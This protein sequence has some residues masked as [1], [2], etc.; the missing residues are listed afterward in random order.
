M[1]IEGGFQLTPF[2]KKVKLL[3][4]FIALDYKVIKKK[5]NISE[6]L[7]IAKKL[8]FFHQPRSEATS[9]DCVNGVCPVHMFT[10]R[11]SLGYK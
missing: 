10:T 6:F 8:A 3:S 11:Y 2:L 5:K 7:R 9:S 1:T 4:N